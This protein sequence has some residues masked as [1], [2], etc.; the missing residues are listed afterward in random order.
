VLGAYELPTPELLMA[1]QGLSRAAADLYLAADVIDLHV[2]SFSFYRA[3]GYHPHKRHSPGLHGGLVVGQADIPRLLEAGVRGACWV[4]TGHP[5]RSPDAREDAFARL[6][7]ELCELLEQADNQVALVENASQYQE[8]RAR[9]QHAAFLGV[10][11][12]HAFPP[13]PSTL[14]RLP[15]DL[16]RITLLHLTDTAWGSTSAPSPWR[17]GRGLSQLAREFIARMNEL[18]IAVDLAHVHPEGFWAA[19]ESSDPTLPIWVTHTGVQGAHRHWRNLDDQQLRAVAARGGT[20]GIMYH[21]AY[22]G[23]PLFA[24]RLSSVVRHIRHAVSVI[25]SEHVSLG[26]DWDGA[27]CTPRDMPTCLELPRLVQALLEDGMPELDIH[28]VLGKSALRAI[29][30]LKGS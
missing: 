20:V 2:E 16:L 27:I 17:R 7:R 19:L 28:N 24:G 13:D 26:S 18:R 6:Y 4:I 10:Q 30:E 12:A 15:G 5:L 22:L 8:A 9:G 11:G 23:D 3:L 21:S 29:R 1:R 14:D 25:G